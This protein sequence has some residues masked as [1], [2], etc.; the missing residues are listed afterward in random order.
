MDYGDGPRPV[1][2]PHAWRQEVPVAWEGPAVYRTTV[3]VENED[4]WLVFQGVSYRAVVSINGQEALTHDGIWDEFAVPLGAHVGGGIE[5]EV[6]V[7]KNGGE[8][9][10]VRR[11][12]SGFL[13]YVFHTFGGIYGGVRIV[14]SPS[15]PTMVQ[16]NSIEVPSP[17][18]HTRVSQ[19]FPIRGRVREGADE[20][21]IV[22]QSS[23]PVPAS[24]MKVEGRRLFVDG[25]PFF[26]RGVLN[27]GWY[28]E[29]GHTNPS[30]DAVR[31]EIRTVKAMGFNT[32]KFC[33][34]V[35]RHRF[36][37]ILDE[38][39][40][41]AWLELPLWSPDK[42]P[43]FQEAMAS[44]I[45]RIVEQFK[46]HTNI[47]AWTV[48]C[49]LGA[50]TT[51]DFRQ[52]MV[53]F[54]KQGTGCPL[55]KDD[56]GG[57]E[58]YGGD[59]R[60]YGTFEDFHPYCDTHFY[61]QVIESL[62]QG[63]REKK[64]ILLGEFNDFDVH[65]DLRELNSYM[66]YW[67]SDDPAL[68]DQGVRWQHDLPRILKESRWATQESKTL[69]ESSRSKGEWVRLKVMES[70][71]AC[72]DISGFVVT[73]WRHTPISTSG[74][75]DDALRSIYPLEALAHWNGAVNFFLVPFR[76]PP[77][78]IGGNRPG[79]LDTQCFFESTI[80]FRVGCHTEEPKKGTCNWSIAGVSGRAVKCSMNA[81]ERRV[82]ADIT[83]EDVPPGDHLLEVEFA[84]V[85]R[86]WPVW[87]VP[88]L[89]KSSFVDWRI[90][91]Q[92]SE[93]LVPGDNPGFNLMTVELNEEAIERAERGA[94]VVCVL[95]SG[96][97]TVP[98]PFWRECAF[99]VLRSSSLPIKGERGC[100]WHK[101]YG[102]APDAALAP[103]YLKERLGEYDVHM[104]RVDTR[105]YSEHPYIV[106]ARRGAGK[107]LVTSLKPQGGHGAQPHGIQNNPSG[108]EF[109]RW[110]LKGDW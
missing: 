48:G 97:G 69:H 28:P 83:V 104:N 74:M 79:W 65:R 85:R 86:T 88:P 23:S 16:P 7:T 89:D 93:I 12:L 67:A 81:L 45:E 29:L 108:A 33:L 22:A 11:V 71:H 26:M 105:T 51:S 14:R 19:E 99:E 18:A 64:P 107:I 44:E 103:T 56:S 21:P 60:E 87:V 110:M 84:G 62:R 27:W 106:T 37:E 10:P 47:I 73:G 17:D 49:E 101:L 66:P 55:V 40:M 78:I 36:F 25:K 95:Q 109:M 9:F 41:F 2:L 70:V 98:M 46:R 38:E 42:D 91:A 4:E 90:D 72:P 54:V 68:N 1:Q 80:S 61:P 8:T 76:R 63:P 43:Q 96:E 100:A 102:L 53:V 92:A 35:P 82:V 5:V 94:N 58:M 32:I 31:Q 20:R 34:W 30:D 39:G 59:L 77:W 6:R 13:P 24:R 3:K 50:A 57:A 15:D 52:R 75:V